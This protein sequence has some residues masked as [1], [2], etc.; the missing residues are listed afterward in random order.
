MHTRPSQIEPTTTSQ[1]RYVEIYNYCVF[2]RG[3][4]YFY[5]YEAT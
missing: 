1:E 2:L 3:L 4:H 5:A